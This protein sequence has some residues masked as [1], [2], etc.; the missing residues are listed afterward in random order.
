MKIY[1]LSTDPIEAIKSL[2]DRH[3]IRLRQQAVHD[4]LMAT[5]AHREYNWRLFGRPTNTQYETSFPPASEE[6]VEQDQRAYAESIIFKENVRW[7]RRR[8]PD[9]LTKRIHFPEIDIQI[10]RLVAEN[11]K[12]FNKS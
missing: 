3:I 9:F 4:S 6:I 5:L 1:Y 8:V 12:Q 7:T 2:H 11:A 10:A